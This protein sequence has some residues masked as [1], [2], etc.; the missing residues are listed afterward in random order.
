[1]EQ[2]D[3]LRIELDYLVHYRSE[4]GGLRAI[5]IEAPGLASVVEKRCDG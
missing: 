4:I 3:D 2:W 1:M 5:A